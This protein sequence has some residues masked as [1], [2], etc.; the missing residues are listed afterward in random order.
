MFFSTSRL[1]KYGSFFR[2]S[3]G[4]ASA[5]WRIFRLHDKSSSEDIAAILGMSKKSFKKA[6]GTLYK[7]KLI[8]LKEDGIY[9]V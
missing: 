5:Q 3:D 1:K 2:T 7:Q 9:K 8:V 6:I 4:S